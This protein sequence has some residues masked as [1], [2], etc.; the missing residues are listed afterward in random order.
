MIGAE[1]CEG[2]LKAAEAAVDDRVEAPHRTGPGMVRQHALAAGPRQAR[3]LAP[4]LRARAGWRRAVPPAC[5][6]PAGARPALRRRRPRRRGWQTTGTPIAI[7]SRILFCVPRAMRSGATVSAARVHVGPHV[8]HR[9]G[10][11]DAGELAEPAHR[12]RRVGAD[13]R[14]LSAGRCARSSGSTSAQNSNMHCWLG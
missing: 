13:D 12:R 7:D 3:A 14:S 2:V 9:A 10:H 6:P 8:G 11:R 4:G 1:S 5:R